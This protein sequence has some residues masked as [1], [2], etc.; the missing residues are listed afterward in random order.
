MSDGAGI[1]EVALHIL[2]VDGDAI[3]AGM[4]PRLRRG[5]D[6]YE[7]TQ[8]GPFGVPAAHAALEAL[9]A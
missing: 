2:R 8:R 1:N 4:Q 6:S 9:K 7:L 5:G 3:D